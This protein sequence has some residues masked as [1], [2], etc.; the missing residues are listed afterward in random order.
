MRI[1][2]GTGIPASELI[3][4][5]SERELADLLYNNA[6]E[7]SS[8]RI[9]RAIVEA[10]S[11]AAVRDS[12]ALAEIVAR[13]APGVYR[14]GRG[15]PPP[16][17]ATATFQALRIAVN[18]ELTRL[19]ELLEG[20]LAALREGGRLGVISFHSLEDREVKYFFREKNRECTSPPG[21]EPKRSKG[22]GSPLE[23]PIGNCGGRRIVTILTRKAVG[24]GE[25]ECRSNPPSRSAKLRVVEKVLSE[26]DQR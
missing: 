6:G 5:L 10:R 25:E 21:T 7:R 24:P 9:A 14:K 20:A 4:R 17:P 16:H 18:G 11:Q 2:T 8:R 22:E 12:A 13:A 23:S 26:E 19:R 15:R 1:D 3:A